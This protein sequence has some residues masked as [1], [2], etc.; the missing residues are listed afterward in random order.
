MLG[1]GLGC[2]SDSGLAEEF[3][4][5]SLLLDGSDEYVT[6]GGVGVAPANSTIKPITGG[7]T[8][9]VWVKYDPETPE[10][11]DKGPYFDNT[12]H[13]IINA[14]RAGGTS[15][16]YRTSRFHALISLID[17]DGN[18]GTLQ[19]LAPAGKMH[20]PPD[21]N[22][23]VGYLYKENGWHFVVMTW[24]GNKVITL[25]VDGGTSQQGTAGGAGNLPNF[26]SEVVSV[27]HGSD[28]SGNN[29][30]GVNK[31]FTF[32]STADGGG[33]AGSIGTDTGVL[34]GTGLLNAGGSSGAQMF[35]GNIGDMA[36]WDVALTNSEIEALYNNHR[37]VDMSTTQTSNLQGYWRMKKGNGTVLE[38]LTGNVLNTGG[39]AINATL[40]S[41][42]GWSADNPTNTHEPNVLLGGYV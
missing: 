18:T 32:Y 36:I 35:E 16:S 24:D 19:V 10:N 25:Y 31:W 30:D 7:L 40:E 22:N 9:A 11:A 1:S 29:P 42:T 4:P 38:E 5:Y 21:P 12:T 37:P 27:T 8:Y 2:A 34:V 17:G 20:K 28:P 26:G 6:L 15:L 14:T 33:A 13:N 41:G 23:G 39:A 3:M